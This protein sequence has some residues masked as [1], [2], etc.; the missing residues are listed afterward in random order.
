MTH[1]ED[2]GAASAARI[3][4]TAQAVAP[5]AFSDARRALAAVLLSAGL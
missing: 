5:A 2:P 3:V 4:S 1:R